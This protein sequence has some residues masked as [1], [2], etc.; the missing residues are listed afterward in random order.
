MS[1]EVTG[2]DGELDK[3]IFSFTNLFPSMEGQHELEVLLIDQSGQIS[4]FTLM[5]NFE[6]IRPFVNFE[7]PELIDLT[8][9]NSKAD[10]E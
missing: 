1:I 6:F 4:N 9:E 3:N 7:V 2:I 8:F 5:L 10:K